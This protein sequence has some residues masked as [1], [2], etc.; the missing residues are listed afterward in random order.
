MKSQLVGA[1]LGALVGLGLAATAQ[2][3]PAG[4]TRSATVAGDKADA[5]TQ[6]RGRHWRRHR[7]GHYHH[8]HYRPRYGYYYG[9][10][11]Y[12]GWAP[13]RYYRPYYG[14]YGGYRHHYRPGFSIWF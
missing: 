6:V 10:P 7:H 1:A 8:R 2:A 4:V 12:Y 3:A 11:Y 9:S 5:A 14:Y 13:R